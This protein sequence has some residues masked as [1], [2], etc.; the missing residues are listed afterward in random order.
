MAA[1][2]TDSAKLVVLVPCGVGCAPFV[3]K[4]SYVLDQTELPRGRLRSRLDAHPAGILDW[5]RVNR[6]PYNVCRRRG[7]DVCPLP[8]T[9]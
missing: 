4:I 6:R 5:V 8:L 1:T 2:L 9:I 7:R 3:R